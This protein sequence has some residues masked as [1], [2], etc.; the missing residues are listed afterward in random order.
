MEVGREGRLEEE[1]IKGGRIQKGG[2]M[3]AS[4]TL[5]STSVTL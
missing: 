4:W 5:T 2:L 3:E 1:Q